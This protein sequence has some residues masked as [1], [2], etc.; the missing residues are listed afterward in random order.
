M[1]ATGQAISSA[2]LAKAI[3]RIFSWRVVSIGLA[4]FKFMSL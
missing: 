4:G 2:P 3:Q 1:R